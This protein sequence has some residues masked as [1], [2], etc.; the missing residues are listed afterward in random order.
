[1]D[2]QEILITI[3]I[4]A[5]IGF[6]FYE[7]TKGYTN[8]VFS[9]SKKLFNLLTGKSKFKRKGKSEKVLKCADCK[10][11]DCDYRVIDADCVYDKELKWNRR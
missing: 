4:F 5:I 11:S 10:R 1:M 2:V 6:K 8:K 7:V 9:G 3:I